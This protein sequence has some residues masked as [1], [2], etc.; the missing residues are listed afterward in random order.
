[1]VKFAP[2]GGT[3][4]RTSRTRTP[5]AS[6]PPATYNGR[7]NGDGI[8]GKAMKRP[9]DKERAGPGAAREA[10]VPTAGTRPES[11]VDS[12][13][14]WYVAEGK[15]GQQLL[16]QGQ[17]GQATEGFE[18]ILTRLGETPSYGRAGIL[19]RLGRWLHVGGRARL[20]VGRLRG[21]GEF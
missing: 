10:D 4:T 16:D 3:S 18:G 14:A 2:S 8:R 6:P 7:P 19:R 9:K 20:P 1:M 15:R 5:T 12:S 17:A 11:G 21:G 13:P